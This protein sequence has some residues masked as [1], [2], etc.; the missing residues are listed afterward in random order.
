MAPG[1][2]GPLRADR[3]PPRA[4]HSRHAPGRW[5][6]RLDRLA[7]GKAVA[8]VGAVLGRTFA[9]ELLRA[10]APL[11]E[12]ELWRGLVQLVRA[13]V[14]SP[15]GYRRRPRIRS[16]MPCSRRQPTSH[17][18]GA[19]RQQYHLC[20]AQ[21]VAEQF[22]QTAETQPELLAQHYTEAGLAEEAGTGSG[23]A[24]GAMHGLPLWKRLRTARKASPCSR[25][26]RTP[27]ARPA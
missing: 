13:E 11:D 24:S 16:S 10:V 12:L 14:L 22:P 8:Q 27:R 6:A 25:H 9:Y 5:R 18:S 15:A 7:D 17:C 4:G 21:V 20:T 2:G 23:R 19:L 26:C 3:A 1:T